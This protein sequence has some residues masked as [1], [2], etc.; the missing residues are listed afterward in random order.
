MTIADRWTDR[1]RALGRTIIL[2]EYEEIGRAH[3]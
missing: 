1:A 2:P 3:V